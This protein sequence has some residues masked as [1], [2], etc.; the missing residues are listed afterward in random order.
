VDRGELRKAYVYFLEKYRRLEALA[1]AY[2]AA[3]ERLLFY[4][5]L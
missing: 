5:D 4:D 1:A 3:G 2:R